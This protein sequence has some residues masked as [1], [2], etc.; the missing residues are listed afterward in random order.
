[1]D[2]TAY[3]SAI[4]TI[5]K[6]TNSYINDIIL[7]DVKPNNYNYL[8]GLTFKF[9]NTFAK[10][11]MSNNLEDIKIKFRDLYYKDDLI[12]FCNIELLN[13]YFK[14]YD[15]SF[16]KDNK[17]II[18][19]LSLN[20]I[21]IT[22][23]IDFTII[24]NYFLDNNETIQNILNN[25]NDEFIKK[26]RVIERDIHHLIGRYTSSYKENDN[27]QTINSNLLK[28]KEEFSFIYN[29]NNLSLFCDINSIL[30]KNSV[31]D[32]NGFYIYKSIY[33]NSRLLKFLL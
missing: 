30:I 3:K 12:I 29:K 17:N 26:Y 32:H 21:N 25:K 31:I 13:K 1:M 23:I 11:N 4:E 15:N 33:K 22:N 2:L 27:P 9:I 6:D 5:I 10:I 7:A 19:Q 28:M 18:E 16:L 24:L 14:D 8:Y 20:T